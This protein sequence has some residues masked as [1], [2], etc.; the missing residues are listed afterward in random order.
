MEGVAR[1]AVKEPQDVVL[2]ARAEW[3]QGVKGRVGGRDSRSRRLRLSSCRVMY[4]VKIPFRGP[5]LAQ[6]VSIVKLEDLRR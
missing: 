6:R 2:A 1:A 5:R 3:E 4:L